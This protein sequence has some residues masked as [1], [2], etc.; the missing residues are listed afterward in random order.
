M[1]CRRSSREAFRQKGGRIAWRDAYALKG[2]K[3]MFAAMFTATPRAEIHRR[4]CPFHIA[5]SAENARQA[6]LSRNTDDEAGLASAHAE[7]T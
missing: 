1:K 6:K 2:P 5:G 7:I 4:V 3:G